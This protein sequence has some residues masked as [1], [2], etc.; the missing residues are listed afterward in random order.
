MSSNKSGMR[1]A[2][3]DSGPSLA[4]TLLKIVAIG[5]AGGA[6]LIGG[7]MKLGEQIENKQREDYIRLEEEREAQKEAVRAAAANDAENAEETAKEH[8][9]EPDEATAPAPETESSEQAA[10]ETDKTEEE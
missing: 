6:A 7:A 9:A 3:R 8:F 10:D 4:G 1:P 2:R 5:V